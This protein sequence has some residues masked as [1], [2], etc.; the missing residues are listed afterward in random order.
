MIINGETYPNWTVIGTTGNPKNQW[1]GVQY[2]FT[3]DEN[4]A[5]VIYQILGKFAIVKRPFHYSDI[6]YLR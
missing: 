5:D 2:H 4:M 3:D 1:I 6:A